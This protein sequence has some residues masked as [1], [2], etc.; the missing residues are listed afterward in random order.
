MRTRHDG[1]ETRRR[2]AGERQKEHDALK[3]SQKLAK[4]KT[5]RGESKREMLKIGADVS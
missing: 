5:R 2:E 1:T 3:P 4:M